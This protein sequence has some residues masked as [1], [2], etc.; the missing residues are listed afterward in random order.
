MPELLSCFHTFIFIQPT[1]KRK[2]ICSFLICGTVQV[3]ISGSHCEAS[4]EIVIVV[5]LIHTYVCMYIYIYSREKQSWEKTIVELAKCCQYD[6]FHFSTSEMSFL[7]IY[8]QKRCHCIF[9]RSSFYLVIVSFLIYLI[10]ICRGSFKAPFQLSRGTVNFSDTFCLNLL[11][12]VTCFYVALCDY[13]HLSCSP[14]WDAS[15]SKLYLNIT[16]FN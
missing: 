5:R 15:K 4:P 8:R 1:C 11:F 12:T 14:M 16:T 10:L 7:H 9:L 3:S 13:V 6:V 2:Y